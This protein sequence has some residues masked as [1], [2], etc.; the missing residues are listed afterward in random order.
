M[1]ISGIQNGY[2]QTQMVSTMQSQLTQLET[3]LGTGEVSQNYAGIGDNRG[4]ALSLQAQIAQLGNSSNVMST[5]G[6]RL[7]S[8]QNALTAI[9]TS[10]NTVQQSLI[11]S[12]FTLDQNGQTPDQ[13]TA[14][15]QLGEIVDALNTQVGDTYIFSGTAANTPAVASV[16]QILN[17]NGAQAGLTQVIAERAQA[18]LGADGLGRLVIPPPGD[19]P[20]EIAGSG[21][22]LTPDA[23][24]SVSGA[25]DISSLAA[26]GGTLVIDGQSI[27]INSGDNAAAI[28]SDIATT[29]ARPPGF[30]RRWTRAASSC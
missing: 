4:L 30:R 16:N 10:T 12:Q 6:V 29:R 23:D 19:S 2:Y 20:A 7:T 26:T 15:G 27:T 11:N 28:V 22:A 18:D 8:A 24:A 9:S 25:A 17:G 3:E 1:T 13:T 5:L 14:L 21:A